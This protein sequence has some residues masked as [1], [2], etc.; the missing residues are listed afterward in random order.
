[1][2]LFGDFQFFA[3]V[4]LLAIPAVIMGV[5]E[6]PLRTY[7]FFVSLIFIWMA[8]GANLL[9]LT[10][11]AS[12]CVIECIAVKLYLYLN[13]KYKRNKALYWLFIFVSLAPLI[14]SKISGFYHLN[15]F[16][17]LGISY[18]TFKIT[19]IVIEIYDDIIKEINI[20]EFFS[21]I[22]FFPSITSGP[23]DRSRRFHQ[24]YSNVIPRATYLDLVGTG[25][26][27]ICLGMVYKFVLAATFYQLLTWFGSGT[28]AKS[29]LI[30]MYSYGL[31]LFFDFAG[32]SLMAIGVSYLFGV[33]T[34]ENFDKPFLSKDIKDFWNRWHITL[35]HWFR[36]FVFS[37][38][39]MKF[40]RKKYFKSKVTAASVGF[41]INMTLMGLWHGL[42][43]YYILYGVYH[44]LLLALTEL[45]QKKSKFY[46]AHKKDKWHIYLS[47]FVTFN[48]VMFGFFIFSGRLTELIGG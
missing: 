31:Y 30:Y 26:F 35:S 23:I 3:A 42:E 46:K 32:Y 10:Y 9:A 1:M 14:I 33:K 18:L 17:F 24:D 45:Y 44:G 29:V 27:K 6:K 34:P 8:L 37:R 39:M 48:L 7:T 25:L 13:G 41:M 28:E 22:L 40:I 19:Q 5:L 47:W 12:F 38:L 16:G 15:I 21:F 4:I 11:L 43:I 2:A 20:L 36:D